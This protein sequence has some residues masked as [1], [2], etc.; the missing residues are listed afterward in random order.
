[1]GED[2]CP[3]LNNQEIT[4]TLI[5]VTKEYKTGVARND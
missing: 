2:I 3:F 5:Q 1:M 4:I